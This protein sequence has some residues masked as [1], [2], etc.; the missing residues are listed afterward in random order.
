VSHHD[1][2]AD[3][4]RQ[5]AEFAGEQL[6]QLPGQSF[7]ERPTTERPR[8][9][10]TVMLRGLPLGTMHAAIAPHAREA[11]KIR[12]P[13]MLPRTAFVLFADEIAAEEFMLRV[14]AGTWG[15]PPATADVAFVRAGGGR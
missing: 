12:I 5:R 9:P 10:L 15:G 6:G 4:E 2:R 8:D 14:N 13:R 3:R 11:R 7:G 1:E